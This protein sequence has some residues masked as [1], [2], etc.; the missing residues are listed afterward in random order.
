MFWSTD[1]TTKANKTTNFLFK[2]LT[3]PVSLTLTLTLTQNPNP[4]TLIT[5]YCQ[6]VIA[7]DS[8]PGNWEGY[9]EQSPPGSTLWSTDGTT[10]PNTTTNLLFK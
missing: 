7:L 2:Q 1:H 9:P 10:K 8:P 5:T 3:L 6:E 4:N